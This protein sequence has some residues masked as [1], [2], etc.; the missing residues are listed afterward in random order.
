LF[1]FAVGRLSAEARETIAGHIEGCA[2]CL[3]GLRELNDQEDPLLAD[4]RQPLPAELFT[5][6]GGQPLSARV[7]QGAAEP[8][9][10]E[11]DLPAIPGYE[12]IQE[13]GRGGMGVV[14][15]ARQAGLN[16]TVALKMIL[17]GGHASPQELARF[18]TEAEAVARLGHPHIVQIYEVGWVDRCPY[19]ALEY[20]D[21]GSLA[22]RLTGTPLPARPAARLVEVLAW[23]VHEAHLQGV[24]H[25]DLTPANVLLARSAAGQGIPLDP[26]GAVDY[27]PKITDFGLAKLLVG[28]GPALTQSGA[29]LGTPS[30]MAPEQAAGK[31]RAVGRATDVYALGAILYE[32]LTGR[33][34]FKA[35]TPL[36]TLH[37]VQLGEPVPPSRLRPK[38]PRDL[39]TICLKCL[40]KEP[41]RR[42]A[43]AGELAEDLQRWL[44][45]RPIQARPV[46]VLGRGWRWCRRNPGLAGAVG[47]AALFLVLGSLIAAL[48][49]IQARAEAR[50]ADQV[51]AS[52][53]EA[54]RFSDRRYYALEM[55]LASLDWEA[56]QPGLV[57]QRLRKFERPGAGEPDL[58]G[59]EWY[60]LQHLCQLE[61]RT[62]QGHTGPV[63]GVAF[64]PDGR[65]LAS[66]STD[67]TVRV[68][69]A[70]TGQKLHSLEGSTGEGPYVPFGPVFSPDG[71]RLASASGEKAVKLWDTATGQELLTLKGHTGRVLGV[72]FSP[73]GT[74]L[75]SASTDHTV[76]VWDAVTGE[77]ALSLQEHRDWVVGVVFAPDGRR[78]ASASNDQ[79]VKVWD[80][81]TGRE[82]LTL[83]GHTSGVMGVAFSPDGRRLASA[84]NDQTVK[85]WNLVTGQATL[86]L[87]RP[88][89]QVLGVAFTPDGK[90]L[91][92]ANQDGTVRVWDV[93]TGQ[94]TLTLKGHKDR[95]SGVAYSP[96]GRRLAAASNDGTVWVWDVA[97]RPKTL[98]LDGHADHVW[99]VAFSPDGRLASAGHDGTVKVW[100][101]ATGQETPITLKGH[102]GWVLGVAFSPDGKRLASASGDQTV[103]VWDT[104]TGQELLS[105][106]GHTSLVLGVA[107][108]PDGKHLASTSRD[109]TVKV[110]DAATGRETLTLKG[111]PGEH[112]VVPFSPAFSPD[113]RRLAAASGDN[114]VRVWD[115]AT[116]Q[117]LLTLRGHTRSVIAVAFS[118]DGKQLA[119]ASR[120]QT[121]RV[122][123]AATGEETLSLEHR[124]WVVGVAFSP[125]GRRLAS[126]FTDA[127]FVKV[128]EA[129]TGQETLSLQGHRGPVWSVAFS[130]DGRRLA[131]ASQDG[132]VKVWDATEVTPQRRMK[133]EAQGLVQY[134]FE[135]SLHPTVPVFGAGTV[136]FMASP[137]GQGPF[138]A[139][140]ALIPRRTP[141][142]E[143]VAAAVRRDPTITEAVREQALAWVEPCWRMRVRAEAVHL[144]GPLFAKPLL[145][146]EVRATLDADAYL[147][148]PVR[149]EALRLAETF[150]ENA[151]ALS[152][153]SWKMVRRPDA[154]AS[155]YGRALL[156]AEAVCRL[157]PNNVN[158]SNLLGIAYYRVGEY[159]KAIDKLRLSA[160]LRTPSDSIDHLAFLA[161]AQHHLRQKKQAQET[162]DQ[163]REVIKQPRWAKNAEVQGFLR[164]AEAVLKTTPASGKSP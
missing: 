73:D 8:A 42:Y 114:C 159:P 26:E 102:A 83:R 60:Y 10:G 37:Q 122:W 97:T 125:D 138:L 135:E 56:G 38:L 77:A 66:A 75:A 112:L 30:Y 127:P 144:V 155:A 86:T 142:P 70:A 7:G 111:S 126:A 5:Q 113:G 108:S 68:W 145:R 65:R 34:P 124:G 51:A 151:E 157:A 80:L 121:V 61:L 23:A 152:F 89:Y 90:H 143:E 131:S 130:P 14:Y 11:A 156:L 40:E 32:L 118:P 76:K 12:L 18:Q 139:A 69:D 100:D 55:K 78:L 120:D 4:L 29:A 134:L 50:R 44:E 33:P 133:C 25:R 67:G 110:W 123:D 146:A 92:S 71:K 104:V 16:R 119:S 45:G 9:P 150:P 116:G 91:A 28:G 49:A 58:R 46:G 149:Q 105:L 109:G 79:T 84:S 117:E 74:R 163:L 93:A 153:A 85:V 20:V 6:A 136:G 22:Q 94:E 162:L 39:A 48:L 62:L 17:S 101:A 88:G 13:L 54:K 24:V 64:S 103:K 63:L 158:Y 53:R 52:A 15:A 36:E 164:E 141:L 128:W 132:T 137:L 3:A 19:L 82:S 154:D 41:G 129:A 43:S 72:A 115:P 87:K 147:H 2:A 1:A 21:G 107:Y 98:T 35:E 47:A 95:F 59:F 160:K 57:Q 27:Q 31:A 106:P 96:D 81:T 161:M 148:P 99:G 140:S